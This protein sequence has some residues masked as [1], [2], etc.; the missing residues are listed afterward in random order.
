MIYLDVMLMIFMEKR[1]LMLE[2]KK[3]TEKKIMNNHQNDYTNILKDGIT[4]DEIEKKLEQVSFQKEIANYLLKKLDTDI[5]G[6]Q[7]VLLFN[8]IDKTSDINILNFIIRLLTN[9]F[10]LGDDIN[11]DIIQEK[12]KKEAEIDKFIFG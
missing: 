2:A 12:I 9:S 4:I 5:N 11:I 8:T 1:N 10:Y 3:Q 6:H 7:Y